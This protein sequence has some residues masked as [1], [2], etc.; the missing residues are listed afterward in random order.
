MIVMVGS[1]MTTHGTVLTLNSGAWGRHL[2]FEEA[3]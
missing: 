3:R 1:F 2:E